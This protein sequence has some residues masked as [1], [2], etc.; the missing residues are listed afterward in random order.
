M[1]KRK[2]LTTLVLMSLILVTGC[3]NGK[4]PEEL[5]PIEN[6]SETETVKVAEEDRLSFDIINKYQTAFE[7]LKY[8][9]LP[10]G[11]GIVNIET[12][13]E[14]LGEEYKTFV[15]AFSLETS[16]NNS[17]NNVVLAEHSVHIE[18][19]F[20]EDD[21]VLK[22][23]YNLLKTQPSTIFNELG[24]KEFVE[25]LNKTLHIDN[26]QDFLV[27][28]TN[29]EFIRLIRRNSKVTLTVCNV[30]NI[31][32]KFKEYENKN[33]TYEDFL[34]L[35]QNG[36]TKLINDIAT[37]LNLKIEQPSPISSDKSVVGYVPKFK[38]PS[39]EV[40]S[41][42]IVDGQNAENMRTFD[43]NFKVKMEG[44]IGTK[45]DTVLKTTTQFLHN[46]FGIDLDY[47]RLVNDAKSY[48]ILNNFICEL[49]E[50]EEITKILN[51][52]RIGNRLIDYN[53]YPIDVTTIMDTEVFELDLTLP[54]TVDGKRTK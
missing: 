50:K 9:E 19:K 38:L 22:A 23:I 12:S 54:I 5:K 21:L 49:E 33:Y 40:I 51:P 35:M 20:K 6:G 14:I 11:R 3:S 44:N 18:D 53:P 24:Y 39:G 2:K 31:E 37:K 52:D 48:Q 25:Y 27:T 7:E 46:K 1:F 29:K 26:N 30:S 13:E 15:S 45:L 4:K 28:K 10:N 41:I 17:I 43:I 8:S 42:G 34:D 47:E 32:N 16:N 36:N